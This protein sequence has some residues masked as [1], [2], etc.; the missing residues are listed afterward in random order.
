MNHKIKK[1]GITTS[2]SRIHH[3]HNLSDD[4]I[5]FSFK[6]FQE[7]EK[8]NL[9][10]VNKNYLLKLI[11]RLKNISTLSLK[12]FINNHHKALRIHPIKWHE[13]TIPKGFYHLP[14]QI[15]QCEPWQ[16]QITSNE[17]GRVHGLLIDEVFYIVW[18]DPE[19]KLYS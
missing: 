1:P 2:N 7:H 18:F 9:N 10:N 13:T 4:H 14:E 16:F 12:D 15:R 11:E 19:H 17:H 3:R 6:F 5:R 8:F